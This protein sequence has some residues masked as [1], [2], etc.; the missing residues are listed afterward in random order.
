MCVQLFLMVYYQQPSTAQYLMLSKEALNYCYF[1][2]FFIDHP[3]TNHALWKIDKDWFSFI[4]AVLFKMIPYLQTDMFI[5][6]GFKGFDGKI[7]DNKKAFNKIYS[8]SH[9]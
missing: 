3:K 9:V 8:V 5:F 2:L 7:V 6:I 1:L 4:I